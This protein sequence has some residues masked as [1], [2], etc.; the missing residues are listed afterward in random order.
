M[1]C[2]EI[3]CDANYLYQVYLDSMKASK[4]KGMTQA[5]MYD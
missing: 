2:E 3:F 4:C 1:D 5:F